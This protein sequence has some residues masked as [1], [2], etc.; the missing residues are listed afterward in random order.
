MDLGVSDVD[1]AEVTVGEFNCDRR[2]VLLQAMKHCRPWNRY[3]P[4]L[5]GQ[6]P[7]KCELGGRRVLALSYASEQVNQ[8]PVCLP[9]FRREAR[10]L[11]SKS[12][13]SKVVFSSILPVRYPF[14]KTI[15]QDFT[16]RV[17]ILSSQHPL[18]SLQVRFDGVAAGGG[19][20]VVQ[21]PLTWEDR[22]RTWLLQPASNLNTQH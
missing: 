13:L 6:E 1:V 3:D 22:G 2:R 20:S 11:V 8:G 7:G 18:T 12:L 4:G 21:L 19:G 16:I 17:D 15:E 5:L 10:D 14:P 9:G